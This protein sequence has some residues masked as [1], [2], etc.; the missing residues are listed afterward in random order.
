M[1]ASKVNGFGEMIKIYM[2]ER[3]KISLSV[4]SQ[5]SFSSSNYLVLFSHL[6]QENRQDQK[7]K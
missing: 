2:G 4:I 1:P 5:I 6:C 7:K 3:F